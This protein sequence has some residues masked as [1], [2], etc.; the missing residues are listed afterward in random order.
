MIVLVILRLQAADSRDRVVDR[1]VVQDG[2]EDAG[3][4]PRA[5]GTVGHAT[6]ASCGSASRTHAPGRFRATS[7]PSNALL[8][9]GPARS[10]HSAMRAMPSC[11]ENPASWPKTCLTRS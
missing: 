2:N 6:D 8:R 10:A 5:A 3:L 1:L 9:R 4:A 7:M 11:N